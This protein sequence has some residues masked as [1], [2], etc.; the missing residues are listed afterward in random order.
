MNDLHTPWRLAPKDKTVVVNRH[1][2]PVGGF[3]DAAYASH[4]IECVN[5]GADLVRPERP[6]YETTRA[7]HPGGAL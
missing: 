5:D 6:T 3:V 4:V 7:H 2:A 1:G